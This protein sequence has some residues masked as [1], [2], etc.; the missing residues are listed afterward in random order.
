MNNSHKYDGI[1][2]PFPIEKP[3]IQP[4]LPPLPPQPKCCPP[5]KPTIGYPKQKPPYIVE[6][7]P[8]FTK[9]GFAADAKKTGDLF[10]GVMTNISDIIEEELKT[11]QVIVIDGNGDWL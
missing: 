8:T 4:E 6:I 5:P 2:P 10:E 7:D 11:L 3:N 1:K 9:S